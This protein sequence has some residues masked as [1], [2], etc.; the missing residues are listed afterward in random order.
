MWPIVWVWVIIKNQNKVLIWK[1]IGWIV[2]EQ[3]YWFPGWKL[4]KWETI[5]DA[6]KRETK[7][8]TNLKIKNLKL[9]G[10][11]QDFF[12]DWSHYITFFVHAEIWSWVLKNMEPKK[13]EGWLWKHWNKL[14]TPLF[15]PIKNLKKQKIKL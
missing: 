9:L 6:A 13:C 8:E 7:E 4:D 5:F 15:L 11:T 10:F 12:E 2:W 1:R 3:T 14:P